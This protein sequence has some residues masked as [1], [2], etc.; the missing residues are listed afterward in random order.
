MRA[1]SR[2]LQPATDADVT[3][4]WQALGIPGLFDVHVHF[5]PEPIM[6]RVW[7]H[8]DAR[9]PLIG[10]DWP[11]TYRGTD[12]ERV[13]HL[14]EMGVRRFGAL[15][16][17]HRRGVAGYLNDWAASFADEHPD[18]LRCATFYPEP[19]AADYVSE[20]IQAGVGVFKIHVQ[21]GDFDVLDPLLADVWQVLAEAGTPT[22]LHAGSGPVANAHTGPGPVEALLRRHPDLPLVIAHAGAPEYL[23]F[24]DLAERFEQVFLDT[25]MVFTDF[26]EQLAPYPRGALSR[27]AA[28]SDKVLL[29]SDY[30]NLPYP[31]AHQLS[32]LDRLGLGEDWLRAV[33]WEN[34]GRVFG[35]PAPRAARRV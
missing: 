35:P 30:P 28:L 5:M 8:F 22:V 19:G 17:A 16:Y 4:F 2:P 29:G 11:I 34:P 32:A 9:G 1:V 27:L 33:C 3:A 26:F 10:V 23:E 18:S 31:Y 24:L 21:V 20:R 6:R 13:A 15:P 25:T 12:H 14:R 7:E